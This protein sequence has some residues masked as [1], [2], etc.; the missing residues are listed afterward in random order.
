MSVL[1]INNGTTWESIP[2]IKG[3]D[4]YTPIKG[5]DYWTAEDKAE[6]VEEAA[7]PIPDAPTSDG[8][9][10]LRCTVSGGT[11]TYSWVTDS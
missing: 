4:G 3:E 6:I 8:T 11:A 10:K 7:A 9:Y 5:T 1:K 2:V